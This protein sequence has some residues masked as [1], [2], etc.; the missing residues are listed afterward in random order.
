MSE[1]ETKSDTPET[2]AAEL[3]EAA[4]TESGYGPSG[5]CEANFARKLERERDEA[6]AAIKMMLDAFEYSGR[7][8][9]GAEFEARE[10]LKKL[11]EKAI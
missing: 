4:F 2:D 7:R 5:Y 1:Q 10:E 3:S 6:R 11:Y 8:L 9:V